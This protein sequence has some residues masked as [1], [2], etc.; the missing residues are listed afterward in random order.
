[1]ALLQAFGDSVPLPADAF[2]IGEPV[3]LA[4][5]GIGRRRSS[6]ML[7]SPSIRK[8]ALSLIHI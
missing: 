5:G 3:L 4:P 2:V 8:D 1:M 6:A 7:L